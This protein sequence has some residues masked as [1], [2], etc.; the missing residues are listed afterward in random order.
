[1]NE[2][3]ENSKPI[4]LSAFRNELREELEDILQY[5][6][7]N[8]A[9]KE[10]DGFYGSVD[11]NNQPDL[12]APVGLV[13]VSRILWAFSAAAAV[14]GNPAHRQMADRACAVIRAR[15]TDRKFGGMYWSVDL[16]GEI[17]DP[18][19][20]LYGQAFCVYR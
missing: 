14:T 20:Q 1:M 4:S 19:K 8:V 3:V 12:T 11:N 9:D 18:K 5:W 15:F 16:Q 10:G 6:I 7:S 17:A 2:L 13:M